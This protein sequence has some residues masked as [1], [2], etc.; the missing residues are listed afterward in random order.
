MDEKSVWAV[1]AAV[2]TRRTDHAE[3]SG[4]SAAAL[5]ELVPREDD[6]P[7]VGESEEKPDNQPKGNPKAFVGE[8]LAGGAGGPG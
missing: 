4:W 8:E 3:S 2:A 1:V 5:P 6:Q 7:D